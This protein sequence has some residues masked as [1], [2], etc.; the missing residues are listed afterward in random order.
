M[1]KRKRRSN[2]TAISVGLAATALVLIVY[3]AGGLDWLELKT[4]DLRFRYANSIPQRSDIVGIDIDDRSLELVGRWPWPRYKQ[5]AL[6]SVPAELGAKAILVD[7]TWVEPEPL[8]V[9][10]PPAFDIVDDPLQVT[11]EN[12]DLRT[13]DYELRTAIAGARN[14]YLAFH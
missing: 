2:L 7:L 4:L 10:V 1:S 5:A 13:S 9:D 11:R 12:A 8:A 6:I 14:V 3:A